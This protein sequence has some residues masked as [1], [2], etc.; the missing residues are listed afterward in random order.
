M[1]TISRD[2]KRFWHGHIALEN[3]VEWTRAW[4]LPFEQ[5]ALFPPVALQEHAVM[6][7]GVRL[8][9]HTDSTFVE[10]EIVRGEGNQK[11]DLCC[12]GV[13]LATADLDDVAKFRFDELPHGEKLIELWLPQ[14]GYFQL[15]DLRLQDGAS[16]RPYEDARP[17]WTTYGSSI[18]HC[19]LAQSPAFTWPA[20]VARERDMNLTCLG[21]GGQCHL[22]SMIARMIRDRDADFISLC[23]GINMHGGSVGPRAFRPA[24]IGFVQIIREKHPA[25][26]ILLLSPIYS[27]PRE[28]EPNAAGWT[29]PFM[30]EEVCAAAQ[31]LRECGDE[32][33][34][35]LDGLKL[36]GPQYA[37]LLPDDLHPDA[38]GYQQM[39]RNFLDQAGPLLF[40]CG[41]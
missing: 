32:N 29:L 18:T 2:D 36:F 40:A 30:R 26:P 15:R 1:T 23:L 31:T 34:Q 4:R 17:K 35:Y 27:P 13:L 9:F 22:D 12:D 21:F 11:L 10:G 16:L 8:A 3:T 39:G 41:Q 25:T 33:I 14:C 28:T 20:I 37:H 6:P 5:I 7:A 24:I 19:S 38:Q